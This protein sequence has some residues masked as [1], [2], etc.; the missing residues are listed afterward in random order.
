MKA[1]G[2]IFRVRFCSVS[3]GFHV[4]AIRG[5][6]WYGI[7]ESFP[8]VALRKWA[9]NATLYSLCTIYFQK[10]T[11]LHLFLASLFL[12]CMTL[13][14]VCKQTKSRR[15]EKIANCSLSDVLCILC[16]HWFLRKELS[17][18]L[19]FSESWSFKENRRKTSKKSCRQ[20][21]NCFFV[22]ILC[23]Y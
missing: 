7:W 4:F 22:S 3:P 10:L 8:G 13:F 19:A 14:A 17:V 20:L 9:S 15:E 11:S 16:I 2:F 5:E 21:K 12:L 6:I 23:F 1:K 18:T